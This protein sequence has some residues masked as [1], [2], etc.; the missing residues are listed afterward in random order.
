MKDKA[1]HD[2]MD[3]IFGNQR[4]QEKRRIKHDLD[5]NNNIGIR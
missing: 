1:I 5:S 2:A 4:K 3:Y